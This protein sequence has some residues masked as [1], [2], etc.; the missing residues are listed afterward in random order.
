MIL[1]LTSEDLNVQ[2]AKLRELGLQTYLIKPI[3]RLELFETIG[4]L[5]ASDEATRAVA[6][7]SASS[8][9]LDGERPLRILLA[10]DSPDNC[11][12]IRAYFKTLPWAIELAENGL[13][14]IEKFKASPH[15]LVLMDV[16]MPEMDG[17]TATR[18]IRNWER[19]QGL[20]PTPIVALTASALAEDV[21]RSLAA[22][23]DAHVSKPVRKN[24]LIEAIRAIVAEKAL[25]PNGTALPQTVAA[26]ISD[27]SDGGNSVELTPPK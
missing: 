1:M 16:R 19:A 6:M 17:L 23:C 25:E 5:L 10:D 3:R 21:E 14:A 2:L 27:A 11:L 24:V 20:A 12:L 13:I 26:E 15:D 7:P 9:Q 18:V 4:K 22:G 8:P